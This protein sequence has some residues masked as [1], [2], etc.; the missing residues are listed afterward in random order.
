MTL[1]PMSPAE[2]RRASGVSRET[3]DRLAVYADLLAKWQARINLVSSTTM[4]DVW[5]RHMLDSTQLFPH[6]PAGCGRLVDL[7]SGAGFP[8][9]VLAIMG[10]EGV[11]L[12]DSTARKCTFLE[13]V[14]RATG[15]AVTVHR[16]RIEDIAARPGPPAD[17]VT[18]R[19]LAP[20]P[21]LLAY[22]E[23][24]MGPHTVGLFLKGANVEDEL[25]Q[26]AKTWTMRVERMPSQSDPRGI[27]LHTQGISRDPER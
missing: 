26:A 23:P 25:T 21:R 7:G 20:L 19:G 6:I 2:F 13:E 1:E 11:E 14:A 17:V 9:L 22:A 4:G 24:F 12:I 15:T 5:R 8:G 10:V 18:A 3:F 27:L 16:A